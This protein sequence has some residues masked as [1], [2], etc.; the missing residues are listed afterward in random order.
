MFRRDGFSLVEV[1]LSSALIATTVGALF[2]VSAMTLRLSSGGQQRLIAIELARDGIEKIRQIRDSNFV[3]KECQQ[4]DDCRVNWITGILETGEQIPLSQ[5]AF[6]R[7]ESN[8]RQ[9]WLS[10]VATDDRSCT[11]YFGRNTKPGSTQGIVELDSDLPQENL[12]IYCR[13]LILEPVGGD[14]LKS[15]SLRL[16]SQVSWLSGSKKELRNLSEVATFPSCEGEG[17]ATQTDLTEWCIEQV[18]LLTDWRQ[19]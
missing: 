16:R 11:Q 14:E 9:F 7:V 13:R 5:V 4:D 10:S 2:A 17:A 1:V 3:S 19:L 6:K 12:E 15:G 8:D 18:T